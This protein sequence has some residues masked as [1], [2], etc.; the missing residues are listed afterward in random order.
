MKRTIVAVLLLAGCAAQTEPVAP[1]TPV[2]EAPKGGAQIIC[3]RR[4]AAIQALKASSDQ[5][6]TAQAI[7]ATG[8]MLELFIGPHTGAYTVFITDPND[9]GYMCLLTSGQFWRP[10]KESDA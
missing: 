9:E 1:Q 4:A 10:V 3:Y 7:T 2:T 8:W 5:R 6:K